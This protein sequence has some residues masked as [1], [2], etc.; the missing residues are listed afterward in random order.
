MQFIVPNNRF[1]V[2]IVFGQTDL[3]LRDIKVV[4][5]TPKTSEE[6]SC[7]ITMVCQRFHS[8]IKVEWLIHVDEKV[9][10]IHSSKLNTKKLK[11]IAFMNFNLIYCKI[12]N[13]K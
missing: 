9:M 2:I 5:G 10:E 8:N 12:E 13:E 4:L 1:A 3:L 7:T 11:V 6:C